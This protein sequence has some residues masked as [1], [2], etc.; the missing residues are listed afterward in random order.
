MYHIPPI[1]APHSFALPVTG[2]RPLR[3]P[4]GYTLSPQSNPLF[5]P[6]PHSV[7][8]AHRLPR[9]PSAPFLRP[10]II[11]AAAG[12]TRRMGER[13]THPFLV[14]LA[15]LGGPYLPFPPL[16]HMPSM[17]LVGM[18]YPRIPSVACTPT[19]AVSAPLS[20]ETPPKHYDVYSG[21]PTLP[22]RRSLCLTALCIV[23]DPSPSPALSWP[24]PQQAS[25]PIPKT[26]PTTKV[27][28]FHGLIPTPGAPLPPPAPLRAE[29]SLEVYA[30]IR[31]RPPLYT[32]FLAPVSRPCLPRHAIIG[33][34]AGPP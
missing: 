33:P 30:P 8:Q 13:H 19:Y 5:G 11:G 21:R 29:R 17:V 31:T 4:P 10:R 6:S 25:G 7:P 20:P 16:L 22:P 34:V 28:P 9:H 1:F 26:P 2:S 15:G 24:A 14:P 23:K 32:R 12:H 18:C 3:P 27:P